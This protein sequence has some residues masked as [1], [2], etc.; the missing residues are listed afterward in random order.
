MLKKNDYII[1]KMMQD[2]DIFIAGGIIKNVWADGKPTEET[3]IEVTGFVILDGLDFQVFKFKYHNSE[4]NVKKIIE[5]KTKGLLKLKDMPGFDIG[6]MFNYKDL[7]FGQN[8][9]SMGDI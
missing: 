6:D 7:Y 4:S 8:L 5:F 9:V 1:A 3:V 2:K